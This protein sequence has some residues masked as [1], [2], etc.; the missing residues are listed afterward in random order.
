[1]PSSARIGILDALRGFALF[2]ILLVNLPCF[3]STV[4]V[5]PELIS[6]LEVFAAGFV[7]FAGQVKFFVL[8]SFLFGYGLA[9]QMQRARHRGDALG[10]RYKR[11]LLG[12]FVLGVIHAV[13]L[14]TGDILTL[15]AILGLGLWMVRGWS[16]QALVK[17]TAAF[18][19]IAV[20]AYALL[21]V[22][23]AMEMGTAPEIIHAAE[24]AYLG[25][26]W[27]NAQQRVTDLW[28]VYPFLLLYNGPIAFAMF[29]LGLAAGKIRFFSRMDAMWP[30]LRRGLPYALVIGLIGN[31]LYATAVVWPSEPGSS[32]LSLA[33]IVMGMTALTAPAFSYVYVVGLIAAARSGRMQR[34]MG[35]LQSAGRMSL[36][37]YMG[38]SVLA[39][40]LAY[41]WGLGLFGQVSLW[42]CL[43]L[44]PVLFGL[45]VLFSTL[46]MRR[47]RFGPAEWLLRCWTYL[48]WKSF[49]KRP[50][51]RGTVIRT[52][53]RRNST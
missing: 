43:L 51:P 23:S 5:E 27:A 14:F 30:H 40:F 12:I 1:M 16:S 20:G 47:F 38:E 44:T 49:R 17:L 29:A 24:Q 31:S 42:Q 35:Y 21:G 9:I 52:A 33:V 11:R 39:G 7:A 41:G 3:F 53:A 32:D 25:S 37:N 28:T 6:G 50:S 2:G 36:T 10:P 15:Y 19:L 22:L 45:L 13:F 26:F 18:L 46:W 34:W 4:Y 48:R 8:F